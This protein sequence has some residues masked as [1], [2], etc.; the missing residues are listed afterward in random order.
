M[1]AKYPNTTRYDG[2]L[3]F[4]K[5]QC[6]RRRRPATVWD[7]E[8]L[9]YIS[10]DGK[11]Y[12]LPKAALLDWSTPAET[13]AQF[14]AQTRMQHF[15]SSKNI[16]ETNVPQNCDRNS[17]PNIVFENI[18]QDLAGTTALVGRRPDSN[19]PFQLSGPG[20]WRLTGRFRPKTSSSPLRCWWKR[21]HS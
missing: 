13:K 10:A 2:C 19:S 18:Q 6:A 1:R 15:L 9:H 5:I 21:A 20:L 16:R 14:H 17:K 7:I 3:E 8:A 11:H 4:L 12:P